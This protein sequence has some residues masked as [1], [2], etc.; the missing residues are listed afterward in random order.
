MKRI[1]LALAAAALLAAG[2]APPPEGARSAGSDR[3]VLTDRETGKQ[4]GVPLEHVDAVRD[5][6][7]REEAPSAE[8]AE[9]PPPPE[10]GATLTKVVS[11]A[12]V[13]LLALLGLGFALPRAR[14]RESS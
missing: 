9:T 8:A 13:T 4:T 14:G 11:F 3:Y 7:A 2:C 12:L 5:L 10:T 1:G 6:L